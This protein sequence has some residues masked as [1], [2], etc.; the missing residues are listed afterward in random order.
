M[1]RKRR[2][3]TRKWFRTSALLSLPS[4]HLDLSH[5]KEKGPRQH[6]APDEL[7]CWLWAGVEGTVLQSLLIRIYYKC[8]GK[9]LLLSLIYWGGG[10]WF[11]HFRAAPVTTSPP[12]PHP[13]VT[14][15]LEDGAVH[16]CNASKA[17]RLPHQTHGLR[18][19]GTR[20]RTEG[21]KISSSDFILKFFFSI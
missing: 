10:H 16:L 5:Q 13:A 20:P 17:D 7:C 19:S 2:G 18:A 6:Q 1:S 9:W 12:T 14:W 3:E 4:L 15:G 21:Q 11:A 8:S